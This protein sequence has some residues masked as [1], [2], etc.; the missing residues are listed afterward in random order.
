MACIEQCAARDFEEWDEKDQQ[1]QDWPRK[2]KVGEQFEVIAVRV[3][4][5]E[6]QLT[7]AGLVLVFCESE[8]IE[9]RA[10]R[11]VMHEGDQR[12]L[13]QDQPVR[14]RRINDLTGRRN[15]VFERRYGTVEEN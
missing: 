13:P 4:I 1:E 5:Y 10:E 12:R 9:A 3:R 8:R 7:I 11:R 14:Q 15:K 6:E 2:A